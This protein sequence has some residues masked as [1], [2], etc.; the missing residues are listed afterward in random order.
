MNKS[1]FFK[2]IMKNGK[3]ISG[4]LVEDGLEYK[5]EFDEEGREITK[6]R[7]LSFDCARVMII[8]KLF[9]LKS[10]NFKTSF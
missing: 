3:K 9:Y 4:I 10:V 7:K 6:N 2:G 8:G 1:R 5:Q